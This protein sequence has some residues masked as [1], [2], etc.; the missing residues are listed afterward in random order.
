MRGGAWVIEIGV[1]DVDVD[2][3]TDTDTGY[4]STSGNLSRLK[5]RK[6]DGL[7]SGQDGDILV[8]ETF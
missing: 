7:R 2:V 4:P 8:L 5:N 6:L 3:D 1:A